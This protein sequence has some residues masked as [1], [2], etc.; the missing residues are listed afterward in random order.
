MAN[1]QYLNPLAKIYTSLLLA[2]DDLGFLIITFEKHLAT[3]RLYSS[4]PE[5]WNI[6][7]KKVPFFDK[8]VCAVSRASSAK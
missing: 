7:I 5:P 6:F 8:T 3:S 1:S 4:N 2:L